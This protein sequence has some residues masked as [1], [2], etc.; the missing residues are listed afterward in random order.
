MP[1]DVRVVLAQKRD[2]RRGVSP[3]GIH[4]VRFGARLEGC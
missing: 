4:E 3:Q 1:N 2:E